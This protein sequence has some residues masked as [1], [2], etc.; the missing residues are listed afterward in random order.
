MLELKNLSADAGDIRDRGSIPGWGRSPGGGHGH[1]L[2]YSCLENP[3][4]RDKPQ[5][6]V[7]QRVE[8]NWSNLACT[9]IWNRNKQKKKCFKTFMK[10]DFT[11][12]HSRRPIMKRYN[13]FKHSETSGKS[14]F[15]G[16]LDVKTPCSQC[17][18]PGS[19][20][21]QG[22][23]SYVLQLRICILQ[24]RTLLATTK[25]QLSQINKK[26]KK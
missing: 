3:M 4:D 5:F 19:N 22:T 24:L 23:R 17:R 16:G 12:R 10:K 21:G 15:P 1:P 18:G 7:L 26:A 8:Q 25:T 11:K 9:K 13:N 6:K 20:T 2:Q 14:D